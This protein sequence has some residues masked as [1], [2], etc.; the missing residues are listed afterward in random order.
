[1]SGTAAVT[2]AG[3]TKAMRGRFF[4]ISRRRIL[5]TV[6]LLGSAYGSAEAQPPVSPP[7]APAF[8]AINPPEEIGSSQKVILD[9]IIT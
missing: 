2:K 6:L 9:V 3:S 4:Y 7:P 1:M 5:F 8:P